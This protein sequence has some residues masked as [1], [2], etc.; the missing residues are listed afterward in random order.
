[1]SGNNP[2]DTQNDLAAQVEALNRQLAELMVSVG[3]Q[4]TEASSF[5]P[6]QAPAP[7]VITTQKKIIL[8]PD[9]FSGNLEDTDNFLFAVE[10]N[11][12]A[13]PA[14]FPSEMDKVNYI[15]QLFKGKVLTWFRLWQHEK[16]GLSKLTFNM[17]KEAI[18]ANYGQSN[19]REIAL[20]K[21]ETI[22][23]TSSVIKFTQEFNEYKNH[24]NYDQ[25][26]L[27]DMY[28]AR[29]KPEIR[30][31]LLS[32]PDPKDLEELQ[33][34]AATIDRKLFNLSQRLP[35]SSHAKSTKSLSRPQFHPRIITNLPHAIPSPVQKTIAK[36]TTPISSAPHSAVSMDIDTDLDLSS[37]LVNGKLSTEEKER[38]KRLGLCP[39]DGCNAPGNCV[40]QALARSRS[41]GNGV[42]RTG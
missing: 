32:K 28:E 31:N 11:I 35:L 13:N 26:A 40:K 39:Y 19:L 10:N 38:R 34:Y 6:T 2:S 29:L 23:Q 14:S 24:L 42:R 37:I 16:G 36:T 30:T 33:N 17:V 20:L 8:K 41:Q 3:N 25:N 12:V 15:A 22:R 7:T 1:M 21:M 5:T 9:A 27:M 4:P 18:I